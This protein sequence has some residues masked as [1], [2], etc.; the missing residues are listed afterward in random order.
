MKTTIKFFL[1]FLLLFLLNVCLSNQTPVKDKNIDQNHLIDSLLFL[2]QRTDSLIKFSK[3]LGH[4]QNFIGGRRAEG[5]S[6]TIDNSEEGGFTTHIYIN[7]KSDKLIKASKND[8]MHYKASE[9][10]PEIH[11][12]KKY[13]D[14]LY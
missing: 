8:V 12:H 2:S 1:I 6:N 3:Q 10:K 5:I 11:N 9:S 13:S 7:L 14:L 4:K